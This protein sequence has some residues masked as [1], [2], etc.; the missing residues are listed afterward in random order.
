MRSILS[1]IVA[2]F[3]L[4]GVATATAITKRTPTK[5]E[6]RAGRTFIGY[7]GFNGTPRPPQASGGGELGA[8]FYVAD[9]VD[10]ARLFAQ[11]PNPAMNYVC[12]IHAD[13][14]EW[15]RVPKAWVP[16][17]ILSM[18]GNAV[19]SFAPGAVVFAPHTNAGLPPAAPARVFQL[20]VRQAQIER[21]VL[22]SDCRPRSEFDNDHSTLDY[23]SLNTT[24]NIQSPP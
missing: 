13:S 14:T 20:G 6:E 21:L 3:A 8:V 22:T 2:S 23:P 15:S 19:N 16:Q 12:L 18:G 9:A 10:L 7:N 4:L 17:R 5:I 24:W 11:G 1:L